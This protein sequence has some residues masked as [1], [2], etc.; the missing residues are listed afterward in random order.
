[1]VLAQKQLVA[2]TRLAAYLSY[3]QS[4]ILEVGLFPLYHEGIKWNK[5]TRE[6]VR[7]GGT[8][9]DLVKL[10][11]EKK[12]FLDELKQSFDKGESSI[13]KEKLTQAIQ[14]L[15]KESVAEI[16]EWSKTSRRNIIDGRTFI[17]DEEATALGT[18]FTYSAIGLKLHLLDL[19]DSGAWLLVSLI[20]APAEFDMKS[21]PDQIFKMLWKGVLISRNIDSLMSSARAIS[22]QS[23]LSLTLRNIRH[24]SRIT[25]R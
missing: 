5:E 4:W 1:M 13:D 12:K 7:K 8:A 2:A 25:R 11:E 20:S 3:W 16:I 23:V 24:G 10:E 21:L 14:R 19:I 6:I 9:A 17:S 15:P 22:S 18:A